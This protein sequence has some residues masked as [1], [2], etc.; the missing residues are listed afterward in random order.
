[1]IITSELVNKIADLARLKVVD[2]EIVKFSEQ[3]S[4]ILQHMMVLDEVDVAGVEPMF[5]GCMESH[6]LRDDE[7]RVFDSDSIMGTACN[8]VDGYFSVPH[9]ISGEE[10]E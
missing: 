3:L 2:D 8:V 6:S 7:V 5:Y 1:M 9:I 10:E 4:K